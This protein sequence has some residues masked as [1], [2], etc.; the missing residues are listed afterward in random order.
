MAMIQSS[1]VSPPAPIELTPELTR[2]RRSQFEIIRDRFLRNKAA[3]VGLIVLT[4][5]VLAAIFAPLIDP[6]DP[7]AYNIALQT[8]PPS[9]QFP[10]GNDDL[11]RDELARL[12]YG[13]RTS[14]LI[15]VTSMLVMLV[16]G[17][18]FGA[19]AGF[20]GGWVDAVLMRIT[21][22]FLAIPYL[23]WLFTVGAIFSDG[24]VK[25]IV[26][27]IAVFS[28]ANAARIVRGEF[29]AL[30][31]RE[32]LL[33]ARTL[34][35]SDLR[36][37]FRHILPNA[38]GPITVIATLYVGFNIISESILSFFGFGLQPPTSSWGTMLNNSDAYITSD[39]LLVWAPGIA[40][41]ITVLCVNLIGDGLRDALDPYMTER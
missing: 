25:S 13:A 20:F 30:K 15:G 28:W 31:E 22:A 14:L 5:M 11:G 12:L 7:N 16:V 18:T 4:L 33:A 39:P 9:A 21:D 6:H 32:F 17:V 34:G 37:I 2:K 10:L 8:A 40:I 1:P 19:A 23:I 27:L 35:A 36:L 3:L 29:L 24:S 38:I 41:L 26:I